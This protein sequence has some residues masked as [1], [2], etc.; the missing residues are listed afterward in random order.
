MAQPDS[1]SL[2]ERLERARARVA[3]L[4][5]E[6]ANLPR[7]DKENAHR[8]LTEIQRAQAE[9]RAL[10]PRVKALRL[11]EKSREDHGMWAR[12][13]AALYGPDAPKQCF[14]WMRAQRG[15]TGEPKH[16]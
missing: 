1:A 12:A 11:V 7:N 13:V 8:L 4:S 3:S 16:G 14:A 10:A 15:I 9:V 5:N 6:R 2:T